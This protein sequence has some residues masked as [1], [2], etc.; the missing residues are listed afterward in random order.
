M[1]SFFL[2]GFTLVE[3]VVVIALMSVIM[4][5]LGSLLVFFYKTNSYVYQQ[6]IATIQARRGIDDAVHYV[7]EAAYGTD[8]SYPIQNAAT[9]T[10]TLSAD[11]NNDNAPEIVT[12]RLAN[13]TFSRTAVGATTLT[14]TLSTSVVNGT[15]TP[16]FRYFDKAGAELAEPVDVSKIFSV[17]ATLVTQVNT[18]KGSSAFTL[19][20]RAQLRNSRL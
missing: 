12:Y 18:G 2:R 7:R 4:V 13:G 11:V 16:I 19:S 1:K 3:T 6:A 17:T 5:A 20:G 14:T 15:S 8:G 9:S 10:V